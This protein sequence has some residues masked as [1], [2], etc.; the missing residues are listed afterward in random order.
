MKNKILLV[1]LIL[2][3]IGLKSV[4]AEDITYT[5]KI[6][7]C[8][9]N[10]SDI[11]AYSVYK[12]GNEDDSSYV[13]CLDPNAG[14]QDNTIYIEA[15]KDEP[16]TDPN[17]TFPRV[18]WNDIPTYQCILKTTYFNDGFD[19]RKDELYNNGK[20]DF[21]K[22]SLSKIKDIKLY[23]ENSITSSELSKTKCNVDGHQHDYDNYVINYSNDSSKRGS[24]S[25]KLGKPSYD[26]T[27]QVYTISYDV[28]KKN[29]ESG[30]LTINAN[31]GELSKTNDSGILT[32][33]ASDLIAANYKVNITASANVVVG[34]THNLYANYTVLKSPDDDYVSVQRKQVVGIPSL[35]RTISKNYAT[36]S[37][38]S[39]ININSSETF[40]STISINKGI[41]ISKKEVS[42]EKEIAGAKICIY[43]YDVD[44][45]KKLEEDAVECFVSDDEPH[46]VYLNPGDYILEEEVNPEGFEKIETGFVFTIS[47]EYKVS[48][49]DTKSK[50]ISINDSKDSIIIYNTPV[51]EE[52]S[53]EPTGKR[54]VL[55]YLISTILVIVGVSL[56]YYN[57]LKSKKGNI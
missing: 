20:L 15:N 44:E 52:V 4:Y 33:K 1:G 39:T 14:F 26:S 56:T 35:T 49:K 31:V 11:C 27:K 21:S 10:D 3:G 17:D 55:I 30:S 6:I 28:D 38:E 42:G 57:Y 18:S 45:D 40:E 12:S 50:L 24:V 5:S 8:S 34:E 54:N 47:N 23:F 48:L 43:K 25:V 46:M 36:I 51:K 22:L 29:I 16:L 41:K 19:L 7:K 9:D 37:D 53:V 13:F 2:M 32:V